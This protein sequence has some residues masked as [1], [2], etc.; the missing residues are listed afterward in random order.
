MWISPDSLPQLLSLDLVHEIKVGLVKVVHT[1]VTVLT[2][3]GICCAVG[4][5][6]NRVEGTEVASDTAN[7]VLEHL[8]VE[9]GLEFTLPGGGGCDIHGGLATTQDHVVLFG[10]D[11]GAVQGSIGNVCFENGEITRGDELAIVRL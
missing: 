11:G 9:T 3:G 8:V 2:T 1:N 5:D 10:S 4:V 7:L 6:V